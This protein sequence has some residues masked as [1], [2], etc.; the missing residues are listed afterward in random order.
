[1]KPVAEFKFACPVCH[2]HIM[3]DSAMAGA[4][5]ECPTCFRQII[6]PRSPMGNTTKLI[7][8]GTQAGKVQTR[9]SDAASPKVSVNATS[10]GKL[11]AIVALIVATVVA[12][13]TSYTRHNDQSQKPSTKAHN[14]HGQY[15]VKN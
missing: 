6:V 12:A 14:T 13:V 8:R 1:M 15:I 5:I 3:A 4:Q 10:L 9:F 7:L 11:A 2:Q